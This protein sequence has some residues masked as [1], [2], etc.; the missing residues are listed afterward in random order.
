[1][2]SKK[3]V[4]LLVV[5]LVLFIF[6]INLILAPTDMRP[7]EID[8]AYTCFENQLGNNCGDTQSTKQAAFNLL[9][10]AYNPGIQAKCKAALNVNKQ[11]NCWA[12]TKTGSCDIKSTALAILSLDYIGT[13]VDN[14]V[15]WLLSKRMTTTGL[16][17]F[18][19]IDS[20][21]KTECTV[22]GAKIT[23]EDNKKI[24][25][26]PPN[27]LTKAYNNYWLQITNIN[28]NYTISCDKD[29]IT[30][31]VYQ[32]PQNPTYNIVGESKSAYAH[33]SVTESVVSYCFSTSNKCD[34][35]GSL[36]ATIALEKLGKETTPY[37]PYI[38]SM[39]DEPESRRIMPSA[40]LYIIT[41]SDDY[42]S[43]LIGL[44]MTGG[45]WDVSGN[46]R[47]DTAMAILALHSNSPP[48]LDTA[49]NYLLAV[50][51]D[52]RCWQSDTA[53]ILHAAWPRNP[54][55][56]G[57]GGTTIV[58]CEDQGYFCTPIGDCPNTDK[59]SNFD[60]SSVAEQCCRVDPNRL[61]CAQKQG[62]SCNSNEG[63]ECDGNIIPSSDENSCCLGD[64]R[65]IDTT[66]DCEDRGY[67]C[68]ENECGENQEEINAYGPDCGNGKVCCD[69]KP[70]PTKT[71]NWILIIL[72]I[73][74]IIL[75]I[76]AIIFRNQLK[77]WWAT[78]GKKSP[79]TRPPTGPSRGPGT[80]PMLP[81]MPRPS[82][83]RQPM[84]RRPLTRGGPSPKDK[85]FEDTMKKLRDMSK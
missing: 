29:F 76:L 45:F 22:N 75:V 38:N 31:L 16:T 57:G 2:K 55:S 46:K 13:N 1:M 53:F 58:Y 69:D 84:L 50:Q 77:I 27:G 20:E 51:K 49:K 39:S 42:Y 33:E 30:A 82:I 25:G 17:W 64:C 47:F 78:R 21:N 36:W 8:L 62:V 68:V 60:C 79:Q 5:S 19:E 3:S 4:N 35:E 81:F 70:A 59:L 74:L 83:M 6:L 12:E 61:T 40:F 9:A 32:E 67:K 28:I 14:E 44:Q 66:N 80:F 11:T 52:D 23:I 63:K 41:G 56:S 73:I 18:L 43:D 7:S 48:E 15:N 72:L 26:N 34:Y 71:N 10:G 85:E 24:S 54:A 65:E 37:L